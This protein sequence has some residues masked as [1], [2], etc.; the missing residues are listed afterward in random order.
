MGKKARKVLCRNKCCDCRISSRALF[1]LSCWI[2][3]C[4]G[5]RRFY[6]FILF[7]GV[8]IA[9]GQE[10]RLTGVVYDEDGNRLPLA[11][12]FISPD[13]ITTATDESG[14]FSIRVP[15]GKKRIRVSFI[16]YEML[17]RQLW[18][19]RDT[20]IQLTMRTHHNE[21]QEVVVRGEKS[22][23]EAI[24]Q[25][26]RAST[27]VLTKEDINAIPVL[28]GEADVIKA[29]QLLPGTVRGVEGSSDLFVRGGAADQNLVLL[30]DAPIYNT[31]HLFGFLSVF[32]PDVLDQVESINGGFP[33]EYGGRLSSI[34]NVRTT[35]SIASRTRVSGDVGILASRLYVE[36]PVIK[37]KAS[38]WVAGR[39][40]YIDQ[41]IRLTGEELPYFFYD[42]NGK[43]IFRPTQHDQV[44]I[45]Y[46]GG[47]DV[48]DIFRDRNNDGDGFLTAYESGNNSQSVRWRHTQSSTL[49]TNLSLVRSRYTY[50]LRN[51]F[52]ENLLVAKSDIEDYGVRWQLE[53]DSIGRGGMFR[54]GADWTRHAVSPSVVN[55][56]GSIAELFESSSASGHI[57]NEFAVHAAYEWPVLPSLRINAGVR[58]SM[59]VADGRTYVYGEPRL[60]LRYALDDVT[61]LK[62]SYSRMVQYIHRI[63]NS[64]ITSPTDIWYPVTSTIRPQ[65]SH[66]WA[67]ALQR[68]MPDQNIFM[69]VEGYYKTMDQL[70]G[71]EEG[72][73]LFLNTDFESKLIQG[74]GRAYGVEVLLRKEAGHLTGWI[75]YSLSWTWRQFDEINGGG[76]FPSRYDRRHNGA[77]VLQ[78]AFG[79]RLAVSVVWEF[80]SGARFTPVIGQYAILAPTLTGVDL[81]PIYADI[82]SVRLSNTHR[83][84]VGLKFKSRP[85]RKFTWEWF[86]GVYNAY[87]RANPIGISIEQD[88]QT[89]VLRYEQPGLFGLIPF[90]S[91][92]FTF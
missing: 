30:D 10:H 76:W 12:V 59:A 74:R 26:G 70:I 28:G 87:N 77:I 58:T 73:N 43:V 75:S 31:S 38:F 9:F 33:A 15:T 54:G 67:A 60:S 90:I 72:T 53:R 2:V 23:Q 82:N 11:Y 51:S 45:G 62:A 5:V 17:R 20:T 83:L 55:T 7:W 18:I 50:N 86:A 6:L 4:H 91:Y 29:L 34:L 27:N 88:E 81:V 61:A 14:R 80:I 36:Q 3:N 85:G 89:N 68:T 37:D 52:E 49:S 46:Y 57:A 13:S 42:L 41:V 56:E 78:Y 79:K 39:R 66:Q 69:S 8:R 71:Y 48:L 84:D 47:K 24:F 16:G 64:A 32:N 25:S 92:G 40:T 21:L 63:S 44:E 19:R 1:S 22:V 65:T 35:Q